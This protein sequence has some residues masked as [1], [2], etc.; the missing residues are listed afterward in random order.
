VRALVL[1]DR[2]D[3]APAELPAPEQR[4][5]HST[6]APLFVGL[7]G[8]D[9]HIVGGGH[10]RA[11]F[12]LVLGHEIVGRALDGELA[13]QVVVADPV[14]GCGACARCADGTEQLCS[15][16][17]IVG[18][19]RDGGLAEQVAIRSRQLQ[20]VPGELPVNVAALAEPLAVAVHAVSRAGIQPG[21]SAVVVGGGPIGLLIALCARDAGARDLVVVEPSA[22]RRALLEAV[23]LPT[24]PAVDPHDRVREHL[25]RDGADIVIDAAAA[26]ALW[27][28]VTDL[29]RPGGILLLVG[30]YAGSVSAN[31]QAIAYRELSVIGTRAC[32]GPDLA[33]ALAVLVRR[34]ADFLPL[35]RDVVRPG[36]T[37]AALRRLERAESMKILIDCSTGFG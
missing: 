12:P 26:P 1:R 31:L 14:E 32:T 21:T 8:S 13:G 35:A 22:S 18:V 16:M 27:P 17:G 30:I 5:G 3:F 34:T 24:L 9:L 25:P 23:G 4:E 6:V 33:A 36:E 20:P 2:W 11:R 29:L 15:R 28:A 37:A 10:P 19:D 7:C